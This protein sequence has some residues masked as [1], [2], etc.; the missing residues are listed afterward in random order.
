MELIFSRREKGEEG[1]RGGE[2]FLEGG[3]DTFYN[4]NLRYYH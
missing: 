2:Q 1:E 4:R 3:K